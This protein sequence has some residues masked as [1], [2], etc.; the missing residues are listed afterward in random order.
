MKNEITDKKQVENNSESLRIDRRDFIVTS[1]MAAVGAG[2]AGLLG[3][4]FCAGHRNQF[5]EKLGT[6]T[7][8]N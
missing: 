8:S 3:T 6:R 1:A 4:I 7:I 5:N 2:A